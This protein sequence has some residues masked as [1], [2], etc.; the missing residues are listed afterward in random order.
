G[1]GRSAPYG[2][3]QM[4]VSIRIRRTRPVP[5]SY[6][7]VVLACTLYCVMV[8]RKEPKPRGC[9]GTMAWAR[10]PKRLLATAQLGWTPALKVM[11]LGLLSSIAPKMR[12]AVGGVIA[13]SH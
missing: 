7:A 8:P 13:T 5:Q 6:M 2:P 9:T 11:L 4:N 3:G 1:G 10:T 12:L